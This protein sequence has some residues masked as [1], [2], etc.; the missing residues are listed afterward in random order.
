MVAQLIG[1]LPLVLV[2]FAVMTLDK[3]IFIFPSDRD[4]NWM[5]HVQGKSPLVQVKERYGNLDMVYL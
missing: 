3:C 5:S 2:S 4:V 1:H